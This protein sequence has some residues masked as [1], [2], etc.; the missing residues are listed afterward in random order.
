MRSRVWIDRAGLPTLLVVRLTGKIYIPVFAPLR[1]GLA[2]RVRPSR[3]ASA[4]SFSTLRLNL[5]LTNGVPPDF[6]GG[7]HEF[8]IRSYATG[9][10]PSLSGHALAYRWL[11]PRFRR[12]MASSLSVQ[13]SSSNNGCCF[14]RSRHG[15]LNV[16][17]SF[18]TPT[19]W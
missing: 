8:I 5:A 13:G 18:P 14:C 10:V 3:P 4:C 1:I 7:V 19:W 9:S 11:L 6:R 15:P 17:L 12:H 16:R 2:R